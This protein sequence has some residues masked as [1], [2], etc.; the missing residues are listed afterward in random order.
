MLAAVNECWSARGRMEGRHCMYNPAT[1]D[2]EGS[3]LNCACQEANTEISFF[4]IFISVAG[5][6]ERLLRAS[7]NCASAKEA[8]KDWVLLLR[9]GKAY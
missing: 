5:S 8:S 3:S 2:I 6:D 9:P 7:V 4:L 1:R